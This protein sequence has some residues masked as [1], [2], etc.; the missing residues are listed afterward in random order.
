MT[1]S[2]LDKVEIRCKMC[3]SSKHTFVEDII[4]SKDETHVMLSCNNCQEFTLYEKHKRRKS[5]VNYII[6]KRKNNRKALDV[7]MLILELKKKGCI[8]KTI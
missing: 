1:R 5:R 4:K 8:I 2:I 7:D 6:V 3:K